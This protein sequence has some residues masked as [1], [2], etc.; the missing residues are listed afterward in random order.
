VIVIEDAARLINWPALIPK[1]FT[2]RWTRSTLVDI[3]EGGS[4]TTR[5]AV[6]HM[7]TGRI[8]SKLPFLLKI[9]QYTML[10]KTL[11]LKRNWK[12]LLPPFPLMIECMCMSWARAWVL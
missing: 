2:T 9:D 5:A 11:F 1:A 6:N 8:E 10:T 3:I 4:R 12:P 7:Q